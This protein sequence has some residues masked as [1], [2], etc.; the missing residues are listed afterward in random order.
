MGH[1]EIKCGFSI[2]IMESFELKQ[3]PKLKLFEKLIGMIFYLIIEIIP[4]KSRSILA[5]YI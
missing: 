2:I 5:K 3:D 1:N 4:L